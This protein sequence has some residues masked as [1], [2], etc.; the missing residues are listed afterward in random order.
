MK[1]LCLVIA[2]LVLLTSL[3][4]TAYAA[5]YGSLS[6]PSTVRAGDTITLSYG[7]GGGVFG[8]N[9]SVSYDSSQLTLQGYNASAPG[10]WQGS[11]NGNTFLFYDDTLSN[12][13]N[14]AT[15][16]T[17][18]FTVNQGLAPG[19]AISVSVS[20][21]VSDGTTESGAGGSWSTTIA[22]PLS[23]N[24]DLSALTVSGANISPAFSAGVTSYSASVPFT[25]SSVQVSATAADSKS[26]VSVNNPGLVAGGTTSISVTVT[27]ESGAT[28][29][30]TIRIARAQ[31][32]N[33]VPSNNSKLE[34]LTVE[35]QTLSPVFSPD[36][37]QYYIWLPY[38]TETV[39]VAGKAQDSKASVSVGQIPALEPGKGTDIAVTVTAEDKSQ[40]VY[41]IT[42]VRAPAHEDV[43]AYINGERP[44]ET[45]PVTEPT[46]PE[47]PQT[48]ETKSADPAAAI[49]TGVIC[50]IAGVGIGIACVLTFQKKKLA[51]TLSEENEPAEQEVPSEESD[52]V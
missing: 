44:Q 13:I 9:G 50:L 36:V 6:G 2:L 32:P 5:G 33:Y 7:I 19:T 23:T 38:E 45:E 10:G 46:E 34:S 8:A 11:F 51:P 3:A 48:P 43:K 30:Y 52:P 16:F 21:T 27:A 20:G 47:I 41:T 37:T 39:S 14:G 24:C 17:A 26:K 25:T 40:Q 4:P 15:I 1:K 31:D 18:T 12:A 49:I 35:G 28:K 22:P 29:T 42:A